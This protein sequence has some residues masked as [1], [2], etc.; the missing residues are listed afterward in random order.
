MKNWYF[1]NDGEKSGAY[2]MALDKYLA[3]YPPDKPVLRLY[4]WDPPAVSL[5]YGQKIIGYDKNIFD[6]LNIDIVKRPTG[7][8]AVFH[9]NEITYSVVIPENYEYFKC[10]IHE[11]YRIISE[12]LLAGLKN[13]NS[14]CKI[15]RN[16]KEV[17]EYTK[18]VNCYESTARFEIILNGKKIVGSAQR[19]L[20]NGI[21]QHGSILFEDNQFLLNSLL[22]ERDSEIAEI[23]E[24][25]KSVVNIFD[26]EI[27]KNYIKNELLKG[28]QKELVEKFIDF[29]ITDYMKKEIEQ[30]KSSFLIFSSRDKKDY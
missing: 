11:L 30:L 24:Y 9:R 13:I 5:G 4:Y 21:L 29:E 26:T 3:L 6:I 15:E 22:S 27:D 19:R 28:F 14:N 7:G 10:G 12:A 18:N 2:N 1:I 25:F 16:V 20:K 23:K 17:N 8:R